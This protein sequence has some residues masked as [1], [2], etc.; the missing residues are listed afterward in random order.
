MSEQTQELVTKIDVQPDISGLITFE[1]H[2][3][4][5]TKSVERLS[6]AIRKANELQPKSRYAPSVN[7]PAATV[8]AAGLAAGLGANLVSRTSLAPHVK[9]AAQETAKNAAGV[10]AGSVNL[11]LED[12]SKRLTGGGR[13][14]ITT[15]NT[16]GAGGFGGGDHSTGQNWSNGSAG[17]ALARRGPVD[18]IRPFNEIDF[19]GASDSEGVPIGGRRKKSPTQKRNKINWAKWGVAGTL[20]NVGMGTGLN[21]LADS[22]DG[23]QSR[24]AQLERLPQTIG[25]GKDA[26]IDLTNA[27]TQVRSDGDAFIS[28]YTNMATATE[29][30]GLSQAETTKA[31]QGLVG[32]LQLGGGSKQ[33]VTNALYQMGQAFSSDRFGGDEF[34]SFMEAIGTQAPAVAKAF[35][36]DVKGLRAMSEQGK[37]TAEIMVK[38]FQKMADQNIEMLNKQGWTWG[39]V[40]TVM[41]NDWTNFL[42]SATEGGEWSRLMGYI[43]NDVLPVVRDAEQSVAKFWA[44]TNDESKKNILLGILAAIGAGFVALAIPVLAATWPFLAIGAAAFIVWET[45]TE[46]KAWMDGKGGT[47]FDSL[48]G[49][50]DEFEKRYPRIISALK[51]VGDAIDKVNKFSDSVNSTITPKKNGGV[52]GLIPDAVESKRK[53]IS[54]ATPLDAL[55]WFLNDIVTIPQQLKDLPLLPPGLTG[56]TNVN[57]GNTSHTEIHVATP[58]EAAKV[59]NQR[60]VAFFGRNDENGLDNIAEV[61]GWT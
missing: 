48:F 25:S 13:G 56:S 21:Q 37:L 33:A 30:L 38:A 1:E 11:A 2:V 53:S 3:D 24:E 50:F 20:F 28:T 14:L 47:I 60:D 39:Q 61:N 8:A 44:T 15:G 55:E 18:T 4:R 26:L 17:G 49:S 5:A 12:M 40:T 46:F 6:A 16:A 27:A 42:A 59:A 29:K 23:I 35:G 54:E 7:N 34:R 52:H 51:A 19:S 58:E 57:S 9:K 43:A 45:F 31:T 41:K 22:M 32:A 10:A 36:T